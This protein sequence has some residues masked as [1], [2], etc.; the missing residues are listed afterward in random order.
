MSDNSTLSEQFAS[1]TQYV[2]FFGV[3]CGSIALIAAGVGIMNIMLVSVKE[4]TREIGIRKAVG[5]K[6]TTIL[7]QFLVEAV[8]LCIF[9]ALVGIFIGVAIG[10]SLGMLVGI[11]L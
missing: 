11:S 6:S 1:I 8:T 10:S 3:A 5:A 2:A 4:R 9:G 7:F